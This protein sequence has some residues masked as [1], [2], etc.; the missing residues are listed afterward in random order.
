MTK[1]QATEAIAELSKVGIDLSVGSYFLIGIVSLISAG[2]GTYITSYLKKK[3]QDKAID[4]GFKVVK[5]QLQQTTSITEEIKQSLQRESYEYQFKFEK[6]HEKRVEVIEKL[7]ELLCNLED[8]ATSYIVTADFEK[9]Q[10]EAY[11]KAKS[12]TED[13]IS[14]AKLR[15]FWVPEDLYQEIE[16]LVLLLDK[17]VY[18]VLLKVSSKSSQESGLVGLKASY[19]ATNTLENKV[20][21]AKARIIESVR[22]LLD[23]TH[24]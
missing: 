20:P 21:E 6:Y 7:Y 2:V 10:N 13:F 4:E 19:D 18:S 23:P 22:K 5:S 14:Y 1:E 3:G 9:G 11:L 8:H 12:A 24:S 16:Q 15:K 17:H